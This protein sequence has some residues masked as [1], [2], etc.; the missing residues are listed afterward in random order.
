MAD[1]LVG[2]LAVKLGAHP[3]NVATEALNYIL[4]SIDARRGLISLVGNPGGTSPETLRFR[5]QAID[6]EGARPDVVGERVDGS[7]ALM[8]EA[9]SVALR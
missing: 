4:R 3:E 9:K 6:P 1:T 8:I 5:T 7:I 2:F